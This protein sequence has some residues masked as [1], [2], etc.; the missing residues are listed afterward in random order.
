MARG[1][2]QDWVVRSEAVA[3]ACI[4]GPVDILRFFSTTTPA[5]WTK[6]LE[7]K[8]QLGRCGTQEPEKGRCEQ[9]QRRRLV[10]SGAPPETCLH[11]FVM[12]L[13][14]AVLNGD[15]LVAEW[16]LSQDLLDLLSAPSYVAVEDAVEN[17]PERETTQ[18]S[19]PQVTASARGG[20]RSGAKAPGQ[21]VCPR[22]AGH[23][24][25]ERC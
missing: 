23:Q 25:T 24:R 2:L 14:Y 10:A 8:L 13:H 18:A 3:E 22:I 15:V 17:N 21:H 20:T 7:L 6:V 16:F 1:Q 5:R 19:S 4:I 9:P 12:A 11:N